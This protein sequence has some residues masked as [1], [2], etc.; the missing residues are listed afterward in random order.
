MKRSLIRFFLFIA[1]MASMYSCFTY[2]E[3]LWINLDGSGRIHYTVL[4]DSS[5]LNFGTKNNSKEDPYNLKAVQQK[6]TGIAGISNVKVSLKNEDKKL[7]YEFEYQFNSLQAL[8]NAQSNDTTTTIRYSYS[9]EKLENGNYLFTRKLSDTEG[10]SNTPDEPKDKMGIMT[11]SL[12]SKLPV[13][14]TIHVPGSVVRNSTKT[15]QKYQDTIN[16]TPDRVVYRLTAFDINKEDITQ[17][18]EF[19]PNANQSKTSGLLIAFAM[20][21]AITVGYYYL[22][23]VVLK[24]KG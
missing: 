10:H 21:L 5:L 16:N 15:T 18:I 4:Y 14:Y 23:E 17:S 2:S 11:D 8:Q 3:E 6:M 12:F 20:G 24:K 22:A 7:G 19:T 13:D 1:V 9:L